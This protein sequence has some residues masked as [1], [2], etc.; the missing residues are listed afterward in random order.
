MPQATSCPNSFA[1]GCRCADC[2]GLAEYMRETTGEDH[3]L[4]ATK[5][6]RLSVVTAGPKRELD[7]DGSMT[8]SC[9]RCVKERVT[10]RK[11]GALA[12]STPWT[13]RPARRAA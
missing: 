6:L 7:C 10:P 5:A 9:E 4:P 11:R 13:P 8:C 2:Y 3:G 1:T 12:D